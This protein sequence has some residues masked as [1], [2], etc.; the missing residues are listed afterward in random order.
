MFKLFLLYY[1]ICF[2]YTVVAISRKKENGLIKSS[3]I[4]FL[5]VVG[6]VLVLYLFKPVRQLSPLPSQEVEE[7][8]VI[9]PGGTGTD[10]DGSFYKTINIE[11][12]INVVPIQDALLLN[13]NKIKRKLLI[14]SLKENS[15]ENTKV[16]EK[17]LESDDSET[18]HYAATA[19]MEMK[20]KLLNSMQELGLLLEKKPDNFQILRSYAETI[21][22]Y[23]KSG[24]LDDGTYKQYQSLLSTVLEKLLVSGQGQSQHYIDKINCDL[25]LVDY[26]K[27]AYYSERFLVEHPKEEMA[28]IMAMKLH[29]ILKNPSQLQSVISTL[30]RRPVRLSAQGLSIIRFWL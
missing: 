25:A 10:D 26:E 11:N 29:Y 16:L 28:Y 20:R 3:L 15:I 12:E 17:A 7:E 21:N 9:S 18:S 30:K 27:A 24:F 4:I 23:L 5:P 8:I 13:D 19:I 6:F 22:K 1:L 2:G 14:Q